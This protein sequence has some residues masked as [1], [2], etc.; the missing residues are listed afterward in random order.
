[1]VENQIRQCGDRFDFEFIGALAVSVGAEVWV[2]Q[3]ASDRTDEGSL[4]GRPSNIFQVQRVIPTVGPPEVGED[5][6]PGIF[7]VT[8]QLMDFGVCTGRLVVLAHDL[9]GR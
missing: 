5:G 6:I 1:M 7:E 3:Q 9:S 8:G 2:F 4:I